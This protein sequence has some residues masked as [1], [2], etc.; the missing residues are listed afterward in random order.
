MQRTTGDLHVG[1]PGAL[2]VPHDFKD[3]GA[4]FCRIVRLGGIPL[5]AGKQLIH[6]LHL[7]C[8]AEVAGKQLPL[9]DHAG[10][11][12][13]RQ[14]VCFQKMFQNRFV[15]DGGLLRQGVRISE[16]HAAAAELVLQMG[17][18]G[19][20]VRPRQIHLVNKEEGGDLIPLQQ[21]PQRPGVALYA[22]SAGDHQHGTVQHLQRSL[23]FGGKVHM[24]G[25]VQQRH[26]GLSQF[27]HRLLGKNG[28]A[29]LPLHGVGV[30]KGVLMVHPPQTADGSGPVQQGL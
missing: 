12:R 7:Q 28:D 13:V 6:A 26:T 18:Q 27:Q 3:L 1:Q 22:V 10:N 29:P 19:F 15:A 9:R 17:Q 30:Q 11:G 8:G 23:H 14:F 5:H 25:G 2:R 21:V 20:P 4:E 24:A 16:I